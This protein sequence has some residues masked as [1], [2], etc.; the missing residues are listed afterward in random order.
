[1]K[2]NN[3]FPV[4]IYFT[5]KKEN[6]IVQ[7]HRILMCL[8]KN[9]KM[10]AFIK[11]VVGTMTPLICTIVI[12][13]F[14][15][16]IFAQERP[17]RHFA[18]QKVHQRLL[19]E[20]PKLSGDLLKIERQISKNK[21]FEKRHE[22]VY[23]PLYFHILYNKQEERVGYEQ[24]ISQIEALNE[25]F[26]FD[27]QPNST[28]IQSPF[29][30]KNNGKTKKYEIKISNELKPLLNIKF[31]LPKTGENPLAQEG[32]N[33][34]STQIKE[35]DTDDAIKFA[36]SKGA[37]AEKPNKY[38]NVWVAPLKDGLSGYAQMPGCPSKT[39]GIVIDYRFFG[40]NGTA[41]EPYNLGRTLTHLVGNYLGLYDLWNE[42]N[43]CGDDF[44]EDTPVHN[45]PNYGC[46]QYLHISTCLN[47][48]PEMTMNFMDNTDDA[49]MSLFTVGQMKRMH[50]MLSPNGPRHGILSKET[51]CN[52]LPTDDLVNSPMELKLQ[53]HP[54]TPSV[55]LSPNPAF[56]TVNVEIIDAEPGKAK[57]YVYGI[58]GNLVY[59]KSLALTGENFSLPISTE[60]WQ[61]GIYTLHIQINEFR[62]AKQLSVITH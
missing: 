41:Q 29:G 8:S 56:K 16:N 38:I 33:Y 18:T 45:A 11:L 46:P 40:L 25:D 49:C 10:K 62:V 51:L 3:I 35:W 28:D 50:Q 53:N 23:I 34:V 31:C 58:I 30:Y 47:L 14:V 54:S 15:H 42:T 12:L 39:D 26:A 13:L 2:I 57:I 55:Q 52:D 9:K 61:S 32:I 48:E 21:K 43:P 37:D 59:S 44:V 27:L 5:R 20:N 22:D 6:T 60:Q 19:E 1:L 36:K 24:I 4:P 7:I 17:Y